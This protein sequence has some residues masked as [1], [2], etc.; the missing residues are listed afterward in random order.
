MNTYQKTLIV[1]DHNQLILSNSPFE[2]GQQVE[3][4]IIPKDYDREA[5]ANQLRDFFKQV[6]ALHT[7]NPL[8]DEE[9]EAEIEAYRRGE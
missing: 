5:L 6:Q 9:I 3:V 7:D 4:V 1:E 2:K 8:T